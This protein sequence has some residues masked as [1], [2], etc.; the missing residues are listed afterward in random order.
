MARI[1]GDEMI[2]AMEAI[3]TTLLMLIILITGEPASSADVCR[4]TAG[5]G[6]SSVTA[7][8]DLRVSVTNGRHL[9]AA[10]ERPQLQ[11][12]MTALG[13]CPIGIPQRISTSAAGSGPF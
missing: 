10:T 2:M 13:W 1:P 3:M 7:L 4:N 6:L 5:M 12:A 11:R 9:P 8:D